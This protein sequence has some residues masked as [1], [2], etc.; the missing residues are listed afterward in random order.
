MLQIACPSCG[1]NVAFRSASSVLA[2]CTYCQH[3]LLRDADS[4]RDIGKMA[5]LLEDYSPLQIS[6][7]GYYRDCHFSIVG[8]IQLRYDDGLWNEWYVLF[9][10][11]RG[12]WLSESVGQYVLTLPVGTVAGAPPFAEIEAGMSY[13]HDGRAFVFSD[14]REAQCV[15]GEGELPFSVSQGWPLRVADA[16]DRQ[17]FLT[18]DYGEQQ[19]QAACFVGQALTLLQLGMQQLRDSRMIEESTGRLPGSV[20]SLACP[21]CAAPLSYHAGMATQVYCAHCHSAVDF[22]GDTATLIRRCQDMEQQ[23]ALT[24]QPGCHATMDGLPWTLSGVLVWQQEAGG[25]WNEYLLYNPDHGFRWLVENS[26]G[27]FLAR[28]INAWPEQVD[29]RCIRRGSMRYYQHGT[30]AIA[31]I[32]YAAGAFPWRAKLGDSVL[33]SEYCSSSGKKW[34]SRSWSKQEINWSVSTMVRGETVMEWFQ[35]DTAP[36]QLSY[37]MPD[38]AV[39]LVIAR[40]GALL[41][42]LNL[43]LSFFFDDL[44]TGVVMCIVG[45]FA[46]FLT[47]YTRVSRGGASASDDENVS[48]SRGFAMVVLLIC[49]VMNL[50]LMS[51]GID[52]DERG[53]S[54][55]HGSGWSRGGHK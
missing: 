32:V 6:S 50:L 39:A 5:A 20:A 38:A 22:S 51:P 19:G 9:D 15:A 55:G 25:R 26:Q 18:L 28:L 52:S 4:L 10:D 34:L 35:L 44:D 47:L 33:L 53:L 16:R 54:S 45:C 24:L 49:T 27:W 37:G 21:D 31:S 12:G 14:V 23:Q 7:S 2:V 3:S 48:V 13:V 8:R 41:I 42:A 29:E 11:G 36:L 43:S 30:D 17:D 46:L 1:A 40:Y